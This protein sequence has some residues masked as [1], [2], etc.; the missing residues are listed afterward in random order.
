MQQ[1]T[2]VALGDYIGMKRGDGNYLVGYTCHIIPIFASV[3]HLHNK[4]VLPFS[5]DY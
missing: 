3:N 4:N 2:H 5:F 1:T